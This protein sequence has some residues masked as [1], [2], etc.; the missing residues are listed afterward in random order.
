MQTPEGSQSMENLAH[1]PTSR[2]FTLYRDEEGIYVLESQQIKGLILDGVDPNDVVTR[3][4]EVMP[5]WETLDELS[6]GY[7]ANAAHALKLC[8]EFED[9]QLEVL[10]RSEP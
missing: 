1:L 5:R 6:R 3:M 9:A 2:K 7:I 8:K 10:S 4:T